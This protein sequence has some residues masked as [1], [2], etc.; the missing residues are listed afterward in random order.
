MYPILQRFSNA[1]IAPEP[2][3]TGGFI[4]DGYIS[5]NYLGVA[6]ICYGNSQF[7]ISGFFGIDN[8]GTIRTNSFVGSDGY[9]WSYIAESAL[10]ESKGVCFGNSLYVAVGGSS[11]DSNNSLVMTSVDG[12]RWTGRTAA[13]SRNWTS[14]CY[15]NG[16]FVAVCT[17]G[18]TTG[19]VMTSVNGITWTL[20][21]S[22]V[23]GEWVSVCYGNGLFVAVSRAGTDTIMTSPDAIVWTVRTAPAGMGVLTSVCYGNGTYVAVS[24]SG[25]TKEIM[26]SS[27]GISWTARITKADLWYSVAY[28]GGLFVAGGINE[29]P[30]K[31]YMY[32]SDAISWTKVT[33]RT[34]PH[35]VTWG[36]IA[37]GNGLFILTG[38]YAATNSEIDFLLIS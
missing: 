17:D 13:A 1:A 38:P 24:E 12:Y 31:E 7:V 30:F 15:G 16:L 22:S 3:S 9:H 20:R 8:L 36:S 10:T 11:F 35:Q 19:R 37:Y 32:S 18:A 26:T 28:G 4:G 29:A 27:N 21:S 5:V 25:G 6:P 23:S 14:V 34:V 2:P 33:G